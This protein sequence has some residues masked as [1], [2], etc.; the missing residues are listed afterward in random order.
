MKLI[1]AEKKDQAQKLAAPFPTKGEA[2]G[3]IEV[4]PCPTFPKGAY[5]SWAAG[6]LVTLKEPEDYDPMY[7]KWRM[8]HLP[9]LPESFQLKPAKGKEKMFA[10]LKKLIQNK[11]FNEII[12]ACDPGREGE[13]I[14]T[15]IYQLSG[16]KKTVKRL[17][18]SSLTKE[19]VF[20]AFQ[21]LL[22]ESEK[23]NLFY[24]A[25]A[26]SCADWLVGMNTSRAY[27]ILLREKGVKVEKGE[28]FSTGR[29][30]T[31]VLA[32]IVEREKEIENFVS[33]PYWEVSANFNFSGMEYTGKW[34]TGDQDRL[35]DPAKAEKLAAWCSGKTADIDDVTVENKEALPPYFFSLSALQTLA[36]KRFKLSPKE[37]LD[38]CQTLYDKG[39]QSYP[40]TDS[41]RITAE[42]AKELPSI[43]E[44]ISK[45]G[46]YTQLFPLPFPSIIENKRY[47][48][49]SKVSDHY[50][51][52]PTHT[53]PELN[54]LNH[55]ERLI[56]DL[57]VRSVI[58]A[59]YQSAIQEHTTIITYVGDQFSFITRGKR[60]IREGWRHVLT[61]D[62][63]DDSG[64][65][66]DLL[67]NVEKGQVGSTSDSFAKEA[68]TSAPKRLTE[69]NLIPL[70]KSAGNKLGNRELESIMRKT[71][72][73]GTEA[74]RASIISRLKD[75]SYIEI[76]NNFV[77][78]TLKGRTLIQAI[79]HSA[80]SSAETTAKW[81]QTLSEIG[82]GRFTH[83][84][85]IDQAKKLATK[86]VYD[87]VNSVHHMDMPETIVSKSA[88]T[89]QGVAQPLNQWSKTSSLPFPPPEPSDPRQME[90]SMRGQEPVVNEQVMK[91][92]KH[93][94]F[95]TEAIT[96][97]S[98]SSANRTDKTLSSPETPRRPV[99][100]VPADQNLGP[101]KK[102]GLPVM[103]K[104]VL[105]DCSAWENTGC[106]FKIS[107]TIKG[108]VITKE[109]VIRMLE[110][111]SSGLIRGF[112]HQAKDS[113]KSNTTFD[114]ILQLDD[115]G[116][117]C[118]N[119]PSTEM[120]KMPI[121]LLKSPTVLPPSNQDQ[122]LAFAEL[123][124]ETANLKLPAK[125]IRAT[126]GPRVTRYELVPAEGLNIAH[127]KR[128]KMN[129]KMALKAEEITLYLPIPGTNVIG[130]EVPS[131]LPYTVHLRPLLEN[132]DFLATRTALTFPIGMDMSG[133]PV[134][135]DLADMPHL[136]ISGATGAG[137]S[138]FINALIISLL[139]SLGP[140][141]L[142]FLF[143]DPKM[144]ELSVYESIPHL[145]GP[146]V[147]DVRRA[148]IALKKLVVEM[149]K[150]YDILRRYGVRN[151]ES[152][153]ERVQ[154]VDPRAPRLPYI[155]LVIDELAD[156]MMTTGADV[157]DCIQRIAQLARAAGIHMIIATQR[158]SKQVLSPV[159]KANL[160]VRIAFAVT[161]HYDSKVILD[162]SGAEELLG[163]GDMIYLPK[164]GAKRR[165]VS[166]YVSDGE[167]ESIVTHLSSR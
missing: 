14:F 112:V 49:S 133:E 118:W 147:T 163:R 113:N 32:L 2:W 51:I 123:E 25:Y 156:L 127:F 77:Y 100:S 58:A 61:T 143:I 37:V 47:V 145:F 33:T 78:P 89:E 83:T 28:S 142:R 31:P 144:V 106:D 115:A 150:R 19:A 122:T 85:F 136:L 38:A 84:S 97:T 129:L 130:I 8:E 167:M 76:K 98:S 70:M 35:T 42:E 1:I 29:V 107:K 79:G 114:A 105:Y 162:E 9:I 64:E 24:E 68:W 66:L 155:V 132:K 125:V 119:Y 55:N 135:A 116:K 63:P 86:L 101:C 52:I 18:T 117:L 141:K 111:G 7:E 40:R 158:P 99:R 48:D 50:A 43:L 161:N 157:E 110:K 56:Y 131:K 102:C 159:I 59:H 23:K 109:T 82:Q 20:A 90:G 152:Y 128:L 73:L 88:M 91:N 36:N 17:W 62:D 26:R 65:S 95:A 11:S 140:D 153:Y 45:L 164:D 81:E 34:F 96:A 166:A 39:Y 54:Q 69:G 41:N 13:A 10:H 21:K 138:V 3:Y 60:V 5:F 160:P 104:G 108:V 124:R 134:Y 103:D 57:V 87:A 67:P 93:D 165:L 80:L 126:Y 30:Q 27:S 148:G 92:T 71:H 74:T 151:I 12:N 146:I 4:L 44:I 6:H 75:Q 94:E 46:P 72:G 53:V 121:T 149:E 139:Y 120:L 16:C 15:L 154:L 22:P 137:K